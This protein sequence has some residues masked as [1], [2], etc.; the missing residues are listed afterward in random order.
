M[1]SA[2]QQEFLKLLSSDKY[3]L[4]QKTGSILSFRRKLNS[5][6]PLVGTLMSSGYRQ[7]ILR[8][9]KEKVVIYGHIAT[10]MASYGEYDESVAVKHKNGD[11]ADNRRLNLYLDVEDEVIDKGPG[12]LPRMIRKLELDA[13]RKMVDKGLSPGEI[14]K[15]LNLNRSSVSVTVKKINAGYDF[16]FDETRTHFEIKIDEYFKKQTCPIYNLEK[17]TENE[18]ILD[19]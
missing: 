7:Y 2:K 4:D 11:R 8:S 5:W 14:A 13:I 3:R 10:W 1:S 18:K 17:I 19:I 12:Y 9:S 6:E 15:E 16:R